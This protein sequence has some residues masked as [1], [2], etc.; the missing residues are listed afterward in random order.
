MG[1][2]YYWDENNKC[3]HCGRSDDPLHIGKS[4]AGWCFALHVYPDEG[5]QTLEDWKQKWT[6][7]VISDE[8]G[9]TFGAEQMLDIIENRKFEGEP[10]SQRELDENDAL[11]GPNGLLR[12]RI[13]NWHCIGHGDGTWDYLI[14]DFS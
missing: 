3:D 8:Y 1:T 13:N 12:H 9:R 11:R 6:T 14:S 5:I 10:I 4:S 7:G 2:N